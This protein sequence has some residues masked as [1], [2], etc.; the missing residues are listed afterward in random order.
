MQAVSADHHPRMFCN[1]P[2]ILSVAADADHPVVI[3]ERLKPA[4]TEQRIRD[5]AFFV[6]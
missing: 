2:P 6:P 3:D 5:A 4:E 1:G